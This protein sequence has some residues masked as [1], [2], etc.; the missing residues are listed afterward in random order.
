[1]AKAPAPYIGFARKWRPQTFADLVGQDHVRAGLSAEVDKER[2]GQA[3]LFAGPRGVGK[4]SA[5]RILAKAINCEKGPTPQPCGECD[6][7]KGITSGS[8]L[9]VIEIDGASNNGVDQVRDLREG[10][11]HVP[12]ACRRKV[13]IIDEVHMLSIAAFNALLKTLEEPPSFVVFIFATTEMERIPDTIK[14][15]CQVFQFRSISMEDIVERLDF[16]AVREG[17]EVDEEDRQAIL[18]A[19]ALSAEGGMRDAQVALDQVLSLAEGRLTLQDVRDFLGVADQASLF[20]IVE[21]IR[22]GDSAALLETIRDMSERGRD[23]ERLAKQ[24]LALLRDLMVLGCGGSDELARMTGETLKRARELA[25]SLDPSLIVNAINIFLDLEARMKQGA[26]ARILLEFALVR[27]TALEGLQSIADAIKRLESS[28]GAGA[29][30]SSAA[31]ASGRATSPG[32]SLGAHSM[33]SPV[34]AVQPPQQAIPLQDGGA[35]EPV[36]LEDV[37]QIRVLLSKAFAS[38]NVGICKALEAAPLQRI[39]GGAAHFGSPDRPVHPL[40]A[41]L[42]GKSSTQKALRDQLSRLTGKADLAIR[43]DAPLE[44]I[45]PPAPTAPAEPP[46]PAYEEP[47]LPYEPPVIDDGAP[48]PEPVLLEV[49]PEEVR[50]IFGKKGQSAKQIRRI[51]NEDDKLR[52]KI[53]LALRV[54]SGKILDGDGNPVQV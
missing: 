22:D 37:D 9:D 12:F 17:A 40:D 21:N 48:L 38:S 35:L 45:E 34:H 11:N 20:S 51:L 27:L 29:T 47:P 16:I 36:N 53:E 42:L 43:V 28:G 49:S 19:I 10:V 44:V 6:H 2:V 52:E 33:A 4:T 26:Q 3:Y 31:P 50:Q 23:L 7:C 30:G 5:A 15:R 54:F 41:G 25:E 13:Y 8:D 24:I 18:E 14:S 1:M 46:A 39:E 32:G